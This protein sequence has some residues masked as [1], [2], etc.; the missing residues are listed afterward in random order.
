MEKLLILESPHKKDTPRD[1]ISQLKEE[2]AGLVGYHCT[3]GDKVRVQLG[4][5]FNDADQDESQNDNKSDKAEK[6]GRPA[7]VPA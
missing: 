1:K 5:L 2:K 4:R 7:D 6:E 3:W